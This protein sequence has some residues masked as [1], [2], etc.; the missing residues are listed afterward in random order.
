MH[1]MLF[2]SIF[3]LLCLSLVHS[4]TSY[5]HIRTSSQNLPRAITKQ[6]L[7]P[8][9]GRTK[10]SRSSKAALN[11]VIDPSLLL[12]TADYAAEVMERTVTTNE[13]TTIFQAG[14]L[15]FL[16]GVISTFLAALIIVKAGTVDDLYDEYNEGKEQKL[17]A[18]DLQE[19][20]KNQADLI[21][22]RSP[23]LEKT[24]GVISKKETVDNREL[25]QGLDI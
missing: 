24:D 1:I 20:N 23:E 14:I 15:L 6:A 3:V 11:M 16:S 5:L 8:F 9:I 21:P 2:I 13:Y 17:K 10:G 25:L 7:R 12:A 19:S 4:F 22:D 18:Y